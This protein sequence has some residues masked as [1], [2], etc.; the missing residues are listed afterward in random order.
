MTLRN[1][2]RSLA[3]ACAV[4][5]LVTVS[6]TPAEAAA[7][8]RGQRATIVG[9]RGSDFIVGTPG[10]DVIV[11]RTGHDQIY[12]R[13]SED[14]ICGGK[15][16][17]FIVGGDG[18]DVIYGEKGSDELYGEEGNDYLDMGPGRANGAAGGAGGD[19]LIGST[20]FDSVSFID[21]DFAVQVDL[22]AGTASGEGTDTLQAIEGVI[23]TDFDD[24]LLGDDGDN[25]L[26]GAGGSDELSAGGNQGA[27]GSSPTTEGVD[28][29]VGDGDPQRP[30]GDD[31]LT[32]G[33]GLNVADYSAA[34]TGV[35]VDLAAGS[36]TGDGFDRL[37]DIQI[38][39]GSRFADTLL[40]DEH[41]N[42]FRPSGGDDRVDGRE[43]IDTVV[44]SN[45]HQGVTVDL[46][47]G[48]ATGEGS[49]LLE[50]IESVWGSR[51]ADYLVGD[52][53]PNVLIG[54]RGKDRLVGNEGDDILGGGLGHDTL[55]GGD[56]TDYC[57][58]GETYI[59]CESRSRPPGERAFGTARFL[60][61]TRRL[62]IA[63]A[64]GP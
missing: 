20:G 28:I 17:D 50:N 24:I 13:G 55:D 15:G 39:A 35:H 9:T 8:C 62:P 10:P 7:F 51:R 40:G 22:E 49:D 37:T 32:G 43:G 42:A 59:G 45:S 44:F 29:L 14:T 54:G 61:G 52:S 27:L 3:L 46:R 25:I 30:P 11:G 23:G 53:G 34:S 5:A 18:H 47:S 48:V 1:H 4:V 16:D 56:G 33:P 26:V 63:S 21:S 41:D 2:R 58:Q 64:L 57:Y 19:H 60:F 31:V 6:P 38:V 36:A 12:G